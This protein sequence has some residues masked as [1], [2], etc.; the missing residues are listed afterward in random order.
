V[1]FVP[2][3]T[4]TVPQPNHPPVPPPPAMP[5]AP[6]LNAYV[7]AFSPP[8]TPKGAVQLPQQ[9][10][11]P[12]QAMMPYGGNPMMQPMQPNGNGYPYGPQGPM[13]AQQMPYRQPMMVS[14]GPSANFSRQYMGPMPPQ[15]PFG[16]QTMPA[17]YAYPPM[18]PQQ[19]I[20]PASY[21]Q[22]MPTP[23]SQQVEQ[24]IKVM[25]EN[26]Y[27]A[28]REWAA[29]MVAG[30]D[31]RMYPQIVPALLQSAAQ[32]PAPGVRA[33]C[34]TCLGRMQAAVE[35]VFGTLNAMR[36]DIDPRV[37][38]AVEQAFVQLGQTP[39]APQQ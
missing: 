13:M 14:Q 28:Q 21:Q 1:M 34:V 3:P 5:D 12:A 8:P 32:D 17:G 23:Q 30:Y 37:R 20:Q 36:G 6:Q 25:R 2:V 27:P 11:M 22:M 35:P 19:P 39:M 24:L 33:G 7:N 4:V 38:S 16:P 26:A 10:M 9:G 15:N 31:W 29:Q 18:M